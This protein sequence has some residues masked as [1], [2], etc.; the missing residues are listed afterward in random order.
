MISLESL[1][2]RFGPLTVLDDVSLRIAAGSAVALVGPN[3]AGKTTLI[4]AL[5]GLVIPDSGTLRVNGQAINGTWAY[6]EQIGYMPQIG[7]YP[8][9]MRMGQ[10]FEM[11]TDLRGAA[12]VTD[13]DLIRAWNL[14]EL[15]HKPMRSLSG[16]TRQKVGACLAFLFDPQILILDEPTAGLDPLAAE[17]LK[18]KI[19]ADRQR[20]KTFLITSHIISDLEELTTEMV[21]LWEGRVRFH[22][23]IADLK[24]RTGADTLNRALAAVIA[25]QPPVS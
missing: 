24:A 6:R 13:D 12:S 19:H 23:S 10:V 15:F 21:Y 14:R 8:E 16:G 5:L 1:H 20:G 25:Q 2:K 7:H 9:N 11:L 3:G 4:K 22:H 17:I 18:D